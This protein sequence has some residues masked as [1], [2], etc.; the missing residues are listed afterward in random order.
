MKL[1]F[2][3]RWLRLLRCLLFGH[4]TWSTYVEPDG[5][6]SLKCDSCGECWVGFYE[7]RS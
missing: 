4:P 3:W 6:K 7:R 5:D 2:A 1:S